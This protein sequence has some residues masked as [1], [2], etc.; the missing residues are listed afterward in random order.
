[1]GVGCAHCVLSRQASHTL[2]TQTG[3]PAVVQSVSAAH[4]RQVVPTQTGPVVLPAQ[5]VLF[6]HCTHMLLVR[7]QARLLFGAVAQSASDMQRSWQLLLLPL[8]MQTWGGVQPSVIVHTRHVF[9]GT[10]Q[11]GLAMGHDESSRHCTHLLVAGLQIVRLVKGQLAL[12]RHSTQRPLAV[13][14]RGDVLVGLQVVSPHGIR[15]GPESLDV[16]PSLPAVPPLPE[17]PPVPLAPPVALEPPR[18]PPPSLP[19]VPSPSS[20][21]PQAGTMTAAPSANN[22]Q[23]SLYLVMFASLDLGNGRPVS[24]TPV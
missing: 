10:L 24:G 22:N 2:P 1:M 20:S 4:W 17:E 19:P 12:F 16:P 9:V 11:Y 5:C 21:P 23:P 3:K 14:Q 6:W 15:V 8:M 18:P 13:S 7:L